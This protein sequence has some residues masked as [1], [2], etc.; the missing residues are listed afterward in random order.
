VHTN[1][2]ERMVVDSLGNTGI[3]TTT[4]GYRLQVQGTTGPGNQGYIK[5]VDVDV[6][7]LSTIEV[8]SSSSGSLF[9]YKLG[10]GYPA[11][12]QYVAGAGMIEDMTTYGLGLSSGQDIRFYT[13]GSQKVVIKNSGNVGIGTANP[14]ANLDVEGTVRLLAGTPAAGKV[15]EATDALGD[16][17]WSSVVGATGATGLQGPTGVAGATGSN[18]ATGAAGVNGATGTGLQGATGSTGAAG[19][20]NAWG[21]TGNAGT[22][23][24][25][26]FISTTDAADLM[27]KMN[28]QR[29]GLIDQVNANAFFGYQAGNS[30]PTA[31]TTNGYGNVALGSPA[32]F[33]N[34]SGNYNTAIGFVA[35][36]ANTTGSNNTAIGTNALNAGNGN[37]NTATGV[38]A[39][40]NNASGNNT[41]NGYNALFTNTTGSNNTALGYQADVST[42]ALTNATAIGANAKVGCTNCGTL[43]DTTQ[44]PQWGIGYST[45]NAV[46]GVNAGLAIKGKIAIVDGTQSN[47]YVLTSN[48]NG[49]A[50][51][52][53]PSG[54]IHN[55]GDLYGG[56]II[57]NVWDSS[58][59]QHGLIAS[60][61]DLSTSSAWS[62]VTATL[63]GATAE[64][65][66]NGKANTAAMLSQSGATSGAAFLCNSYIGGGYNDW[67]LPAAWELAECYKAAAVVNRN[68]GDVNGF[69]FF[70]GSNGVLYWSSTE[71]NSTVAWA[72][73]FHVGSADTTTKSNTYSVRA[74]RRY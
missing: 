23:V 15:L 10:T 14:A 6:T 67:Y 5:V 62:N 54:Y 58:G 16:A 26:N 9:A 70:T 12:N 38:S 59:V 44:T 71:V 25:T 69:Q 32:L 35:L 7:G 28:S 20:A 47:G 3:G 41:A 31:F 18:G 68:I 21:L 49:L 37:Y 13:S 42:A 4:P 19:S 45:P 48:A 30:T 34:T 60:L 51:W 72:E 1:N 66:D 8:N 36:E 73:A 33:F 29:S 50:G 65:P 63:I 27:F 56:G 43:G 24:G 46:L 39:L 22:T 52:Q 55:I 64:S 53:A 57:V 2:T 17:A 40:Q 11:N 74:V 61:A